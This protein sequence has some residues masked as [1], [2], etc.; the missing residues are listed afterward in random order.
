MKKKL[1][2]SPFAIF[3]LVVL[4]ALV[5]YSVNYLF[6]TRNEMTA[7]R[8]EIMVNNAEANIYRP[9]VAD[10]SELEAQ[11]AA[12][13]AEIAQ[14]HQ[15]GYVNDSTVSLTIAEAVQEYNISLTSVSLGAITRFDGHRA[16][17]V[18]ISMSGSLENVI[19]FISHFENDSVGSYIVQ[20]SSLQIS[21]S[22]ARATMV[23]YLCTPAA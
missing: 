3:F 12:I 19:R 13:E 7:I 14:L 16:L 17:P 23:L 21:G 8:S 10:T 9:Y 1:P 18:N 5:L 2:I 20:A 4:V 6:P 22:T 15:E 11:I